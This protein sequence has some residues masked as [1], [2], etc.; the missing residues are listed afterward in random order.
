MSETKDTIREIEGRGYR[1]NILLSPRNKRIVIKEFKGEDVTR[2]ADTL[3]DI[4]AEA[5]L[6]K[7]W[8]KHPRKKSRRFL[9][10]RF[11]EEAV[12]KKFY[13]EDDASLLSLFLVPERGESDNQKEKQKL[14]DDVCALKEKENYDLPPGYNFQIAG[15]EDILDLTG[16]FGQVFSTYPYP[17]YREEYIQKMM[18]EGVVYGVINKGRETV[19][20]ASAETVEELAN[21]EMTDFATLPEYRGQGLAAC[22][23]RRLEEELKDRN[24]RCLYTIAR[25]GVYGINRIFGRAG[26]EYTGTLVKNCSIGGSLEDMN[27]WC[28]RI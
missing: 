2:L 24:Y 23:L 21:A 1:A 7:I 26:Y 27:V 25:A 19:A 9:E 20:A 17:I 8:F 11:R 16:L 3:K 5:G 22:I 12:V 6:T 14:L 15:K 28:K 4:G 13:P 10:E 18:D